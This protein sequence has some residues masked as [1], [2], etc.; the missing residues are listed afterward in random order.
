[1]CSIPGLAGF[2]DSVG[3]WILI[4]DR[5]CLCKRFI[6]NIWM[7]KACKNCGHRSDLCS[8]RRLPW[9]AKCKC[10][11]PT[12]KESLWSENRETSLGGQE[13]LTGEGTSWTAWSLWWDD[14]PLPATSGNQ[15]IFFQRGHS[16]Y[17]E[18]RTTLICS[19]YLDSFRSL[20]LQFMSNVQESNSCNFLSLVLVFLRIHLLLG[21]WSFSG[22]RASSHLSSW[23]RRRF[24]LYSLFALVPM[25]HVRPAL[26]TSQTVAHS[27]SMLQCHPNEDIT[28]RI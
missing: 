14:R 27:T 18:S 15:C 12:K 26:S 4:H 24:Q 17:P 25:I 22:C 20:Q 8:W 19:R 1:M 11:N 6:M 13:E 23:L 2:E 16:S 28:A 5:V 3:I 7:T 10:R 9:V 21:T